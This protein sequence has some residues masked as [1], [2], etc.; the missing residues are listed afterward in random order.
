[1]MH[2]KKMHIMFMHVDNAATCTSVLIQSLLTKLFK[3]ASNKGLLVK[4]CQTAAILVSAN[5]LLNH[6][7]NCMIPTIV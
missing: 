5:T 4:K 3:L 6:G 2:G 7:F 1:V